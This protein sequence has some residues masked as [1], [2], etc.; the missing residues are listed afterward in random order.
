MINT[1]ADKG[2]DWDQLVAALRI[3]VIR[4]IERILKASL[5]DKI[6]V[7]EVLTT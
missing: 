4:K 2:Q 1:P 5:A 3:K 6:E 7:E